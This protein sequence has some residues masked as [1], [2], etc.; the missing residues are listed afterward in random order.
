MTKRL[1]KSAIGDR[2]VDDDD[3][4]TFLAGAAA[5]MNRRPLMQASADPSDPLVLSPAHFLHPYV[6]TNSATNILPPNTGDPER[7]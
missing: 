1:I 5:I 7:L 2:S 4:N 3:F 6:F